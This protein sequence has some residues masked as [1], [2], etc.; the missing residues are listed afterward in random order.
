MPDIYEHH[1]RVV[2]AEIDQLGHANNLC[3]LQWMMASAMGHSAA[4][5]WPAYRYQ[6]LGAGWVVRSHQI[7][8][9]R[10]AY[11]GDEIVVRTWVVETRRVTSL[12]KYKILRRSDNLLLAEAQTDW[13]FVDFATGKI[14]RIPDVVALA[15]PALGENP[16]SV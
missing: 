6:E 10:P 14:A 2:A 9:L 11:E 15:F 8:Y 3:Y 1:H 12:R 5:G 16:A 4:Q 7:E 13:A